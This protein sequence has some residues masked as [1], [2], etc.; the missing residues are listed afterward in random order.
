M[1]ALS[2][3]GGAGWQFFNS[4]GRPLD[5]GKLYTYLAGTTTPAVTYT[6]SAGTPGTENTNPI[7]LDSAGRVP[8]QV[9]LQNA[10]SYKFTLTTSDDVPIWT[11]DN[12]PGIMADRIF[13]AADIEYDPPF[14]GAL[15]SGYTV[16]ER[17]SQTLSVKDFGA[18]GDGATDDTTAINAAYTEAETLG[19]AEVYW[20]AGTYRCTATI[21]CGPLS[22]TNASAGAIL[23]Y[24]GAGTAMIVDGV[25]TSETNGQFHVFPYIAKTSLDWNSGTDTTSV[26][27]IL[28]NRKYNTF[29]IPGIKRFN[30]GLALKADVANFVCNTIQLGVVQNCRLGIDFSRVTVSFGVNQNTFVGGAVVIDS[31]YTTAANRIY[32]NMPNAEN[33]TNTFVGVNLEK[34]GN[35]KAI[36]CASSSNLFLNC[37]FEA[38]GSTAGYITVSGNNNHFVGGSPTS[39]AT[40]PFVTWIS[41]TGF[42]NTFQ[43]A[44]VIA[45]K[46]MVWDTHSVSAP[47]RF[48]NGSAYPAVPIGSFGT[49]RLA[50]G[51]SATLAIRN[52]GF[53]QQE[54]APV[55]SG[56]TLPWRSAIVLTYGSATTVTGMAASIG[57]TDTSGI[58][59]I[60]ATNGNVTLQHTA[61]PAAN[62]GKFVLKAGVDLL[63]TAN[64]PVLFQLVG[65]NLYQI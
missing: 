51:N 31:A 25:N 59:A 57:L 33:N 38:G 36:V 1:V 20:P 62:A 5:G 39:S 65:G 64:T 47:L 55:T 42:G 24:S 48:G 43:M 7:I 6:T 9:W 52:W 44:N 61:S 46:Y 58:V 14:V 27:L 10:T 53:V 35:E 37:R 12:V 22:A 45:N 13:T 2:S 60:T 40:I 49:D 26:G 54:G 17:L 63:L 21:N 4:N 19:G 3:L 28:Q 32:I 16:E 50:L 11:K 23:S 30:E 15:T 29:K 34:G 8:Q 56:A 41:D 18:V